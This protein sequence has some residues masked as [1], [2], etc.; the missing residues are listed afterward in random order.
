MN[1]VSFIEIVHQGQKRK[2]GDAYTS[3][4]YAVRGLL[5]NA[6]VSEPHVLEA[7]LL[8]DCL[9]DG[10]ISKEYLSFRFGP[11]IAD[12]VDVLSKESTWHT[13][14]CRMK[15]YLGELEHAW[16][17][18]P[19]AIVIKIA[20]RLHNLQTLDGFPVQ[21][22]VEYLQETTQELLPL[23][24]TLQRDKV[25]GQYSGPLQCL[26]TALENEV[27]VASQRLSPLP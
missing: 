2:T 22:R 10:D 11:A 7:A 18:Y 27:R 26:L 24:R 19:E 6:G 16:A 3:H 25:V 23:F 9:E 4:L 13:N 5:T 17:L 1:A 21:K 20:D 12:I 8:H 15:S 14:Y